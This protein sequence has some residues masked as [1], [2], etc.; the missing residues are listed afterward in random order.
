MNGINLPGPNS[1]LARR[2]FLK[3]LG[4]ACSFTM[5]NPWRGLPGESATPPDETAIKER[6]D[7]HRP[8]RLNPWPKDFNDRVGA[9][10]VDGKYYFTDRPFLQEG[11]SRLLELGTRVGKFWFMPGSEV[12]NYRFNHQWS[13][14]TTLLELARSE[15]YSELFEKAFT[16]FVLECFSPQEN[17]WRSPRPEEFYQAITQEYYEATA[18]FYRQYRQRSIT[19]V[20]QHW[21]GDWMLRGRGGELWNPAPANWP[22]LVERMQRWLAARQAG[23]RKARHELAAGALCRVAHAAEVNRVADLWKGIPTVTEKVVPGIELDL[24]SYSA[25]DGLRDPITLWRCVEEIRRHAR[26]TG[27]F[28]ER[29]VYLGEIGLPE[30][31]TPPGQIAERWDG[32][33]G[34][35]LAAK[36]FYV[37]QWE[38]YCNEI[39]PK[40]QPPPRLPIKE[41]SHM[42]GFWLVRPDGSLSETGQLLQRL[43]QKKA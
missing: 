7:A 26:T 2:S 25:Y 22:E 29:A 16:T 36:V 30:N 19:I 33:L 20:L 18:H 11:T 32:W 28:G 41:L 12:R 27:P 35:A 5:I 3:K 42:R 10:H 38:I 1:A 4:G 37:I 8:S 34:A 15:E 24:V 9:T 31:E 13:K 43:W 23:V 14:H 6:I 40:I 39:N 21:E 17:G